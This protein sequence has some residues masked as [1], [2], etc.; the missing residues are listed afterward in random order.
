MRITRRKGIILAAALA[1][2]LAWACFG[3]DRRAPLTRAEVR[4]RQNPPQGLD[5]VRVDRLGMV[6]SPAPRDRVTLPV[7]IRAGKYSLDYARRVLVP[8]MGASIAAGDVNGDGR[9]DLYMVMPAGH[10][11]LLRQNA[12]GTF[13]DV[14]AQAKVAGEG[15]SLGAVFA[16]FDRSGRVSLFVAGLGGVTLYRNNGDG[17]FTDETRK[18]GLPARLGELFTSVV[19]SDVDGDGF[20]DLLLTGYTDLSVRPKA[21]CL[22]PN[23]FPGV[24]SRLYHNDRGISFEE[25]TAPAGLAGNAGRARNAV[26]ADFNADAQPDLLLLRDDKPPIFYVN[27]G[28]RFEDQTWNSGEHL[29]RNAFFDG[30]AVDFNRDG[31]LDLVLWSTMGS[32]VLLNRG[33]ARFATAETV[34]LIPPVPAFGFHGLAADFDGDGGEDLLTMDDNARVHWFANR[35]SYFIEGPLTVTGAAPE[36]FDAAIVLR[37][38]GR[39]HW[40]AL[41]PGGQVAVFQWD[42]SRG[43]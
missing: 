10:N 40:V 14:T 2:T 16:D 23:D 30:Q 11:H 32:R 13:T 35:G 36:Q 29:T 22:F 7:E 31:K 34:P 4:A 19:V 21:N 42:R 39:T 8:A 41:S 26:L 12:D 5:F 38:N 28:G 33:S 20:P 24:T 43:K 3:E 25:I 6:L 1:G 17:T 18:H 27:H 15:G 9:P 37:L